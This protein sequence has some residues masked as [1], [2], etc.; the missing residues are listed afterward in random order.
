MTAN[1]KAFLQMVVCAVLWSISGIFFKLLTHCH[2]FVIAG[3]RSAF[4]AVT[5]IA[6]M[7]FKRQRLVLNKSVFLTALFLSSVFFMFVSANSLTTAANAIVLQYTAPVFILIFSALFLKQRFIKA[8]IIVVVLTLLGISLFFLDKLDG[9]Q[10]LGNLLA[11][12]SGIALSGLFIT[13]GGAANEAERMSGLLMG[14]LVTCAVGIP[15]LLFTENQMDMTT[16]GMLAILGVLQLGVPYILMGL[17][18]LHCPPL[19]CSLIG[20]IEPLLN[21]IWVALFDGE[22]PGPLALFGGAI[23]LC[24]IAV[25]CVWKDRY[26]RRHA[27]GVT[28]GDRGAL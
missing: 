14:Q 12:G 22:V 21:P 11:V 2:P 19:A 20:M 28:L 10:L 17:A 15:F 4:A 3:V 1:N 26:T 23:V 5:I 16:I 6:Y 7:V 27:A 24:S 13:V 18:S 9:G 8:D 25:W